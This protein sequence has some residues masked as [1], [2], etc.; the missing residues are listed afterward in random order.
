VN[1][2]NKGKHAC[3][4]KK[5]KKGENTKI[6]LRRYILQLTTEANP[7]SLERTKVVSKEGARKK[8]TIREM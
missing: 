1:N 3:E 6:Y 4:Q 5:D 7:P 2:E 8:R